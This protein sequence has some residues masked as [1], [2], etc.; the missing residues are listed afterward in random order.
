MNYVVGNC[1]ALI[2]VEMNS[3]LKYKENL[4]VILN[5]NIL[6]IPIEKNQQFLHHATKN[7]SALVIPQ[8]TVGK[9]LAVR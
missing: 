9:S 5:L 4:I 2:S 7:K 8:K 6:L 3:Y 1:L